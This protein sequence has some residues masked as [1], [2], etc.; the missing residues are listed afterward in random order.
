[1][2]ALRPSSSTR[3]YLHPILSRSPR[4]ITRRHPI[5]AVSTHPD[6]QFV[7]APVELDHL[8]LE[9]DADGR[10]RL[11]FG[12]EVVISEAEQKR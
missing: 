3:S 5:A 1:M 2:P 10:R 11:L 6:R 12:K 7:P 9:I 4:P 8:D